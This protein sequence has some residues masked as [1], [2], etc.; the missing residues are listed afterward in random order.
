MLVVLDAEATPFTRIWCA[1]EEATAV[2]LDGAARL[3]K[4]P[5]LLD[6]ATAPIGK[7][8]VTATSGSGTSESTGP[9]QLLTDGLSPAELAMEAERLEKPRMKS[10]GTALR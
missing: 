10:R 4:A 9:A 6:I 1:F 2:A 3:G 5:L 8:R 7:A